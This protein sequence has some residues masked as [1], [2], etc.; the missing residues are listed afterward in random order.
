MKGNFTGGIE[1]QQRQLRLFT[2]GGHICC[3][4]STSAI[5]SGN[6]GASIGLPE[7][8]G[9]IAPGRGSVL[10]GFTGV[11]GDGLPSSVSRSGDE[12]SQQ[13]SDVGAIAPSL[14][15]SQSFARMAAV[16]SGSDG[17]PVLESHS[18]GTRFRAGI[19]C[20]SRRA[21]QERKGVKRASDGR[22]AVTRDEIRS[23]YPA[24]LCIGGRSE[25]A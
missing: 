8:D 24:W 3:D 9:A 23:G 4:E 22:A 5:T 2:F 21:T 13:G 25:A 7:G 12:C 11:V 19:A 14:E 1:T 6:G 17:A 10:S 16:L 20:T 18:E 15:T